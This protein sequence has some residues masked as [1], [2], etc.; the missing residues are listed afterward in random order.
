MLSRTGLTD[1]A[2]W[3]RR[4]GACIQRDN[5][6]SVRDLH[7]RSGGL[8]KGGPEGMF[9]GIENL[10]S[11]HM[12]CSSLAVIST[13]KERYNKGLMNTTMFLVFSGSVT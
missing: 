1:N 10:L 2:G 4:R 9:V 3:L 8:A 7:V 13:V 5:K 6:D 11:R 12:A